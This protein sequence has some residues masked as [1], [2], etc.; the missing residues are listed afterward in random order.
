MP[1]GAFRINSIAKR[2]TVPAAGRTAV[3]VTAFGNA[4]VD[5]AQ[6]KFGG[7]S[8]L[9]DGSGDYLFVPSTS[10]FAFGTSDFTIEGWIRFTNF[11]NGPVFVD[12]RAAGGNEAKPVIYFGT[13]GVIYYYVSGAN[14]ITGSVQTTAVWYHIALSRSGTSTRLFVNGTQVGSTYTDTTNYP[15]T[16]LSLGIASWNTAFN[17]HNGWID[18]FRISNSARYTANFTAPA[19]AFVNDENTLLLLHMDGTDASTVFEDDNGA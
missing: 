7:A 13:D 11:T 15:A 16:V 9:F 4:Q 6:S 2:F 19:A 17:A 3:T 1:L 8:A 10:T 18:E 14:R 12:M 5:T